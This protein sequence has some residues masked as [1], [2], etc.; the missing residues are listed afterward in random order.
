MPD[1]AAALVAQA[2]TLMDEEKYE[3][4]IPLLQKAAD[5][6]DAEAQTKLGTC[7]VK[8]NGVEQDYEEP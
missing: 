8:G 7:F 1:E 2:Q 5:L 3:E 6:G 4:A